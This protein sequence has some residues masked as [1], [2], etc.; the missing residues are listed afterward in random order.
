[1]R[2][3]LLLLADEGGA[4]LFDFDVWNMLIYFANFVVLCVGLYFLLFRPV[5]KFMAK[6][7]ENIVKVSEENQKL[8]EEVQSMKKEYDTLV[9]EAKR[10]LAKAN[11]QAKVVAEKRSAEILADA[12]ARAKS[13]VDKAKEE[14][15]HEKQRAE[16]EIRGQVAEI[17][18][19]VAEKILAKEIDAKSNSELIESS[20]RKWEHE[21]Q[22]R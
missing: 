1:M 14:I 7:N 9:S 15:E 18:V 5:K 11:E 10:E 21:D 3:L 4:N 17:S 12:N 16:T 19:A 20:I 8:S 6:R 2:G 13:I 22:L